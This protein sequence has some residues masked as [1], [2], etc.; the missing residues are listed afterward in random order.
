MSDCP[1]DCR[2]NFNIYQT[3]L[4]LVHATNETRLRK[5]NSFIKFFFY[6]LF[7]HK[8]WLTRVHF[9]WFEVLLRVAFKIIFCLFTEKFVTLGKLEF[10]YSRLFHVRT[11]LAH[12]GGKHGYAQGAQELSR[13]QSISNLNQA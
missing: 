13:E 8:F 9:K 11:F 1:P 2:V 10:Y 12:Y 3:R 7:W 6:N 4:L 5:F